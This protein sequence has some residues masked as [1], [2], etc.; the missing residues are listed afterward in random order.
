M[1]VDIPE[2][3]REELTKIRCWLTGYHAGKG[4][5]DI[6]SIP[7]EFIIRQL[8]MAIDNKKEE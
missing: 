8:I 7:G 5:S 1:K 3:S 2:H 6:K 4:S